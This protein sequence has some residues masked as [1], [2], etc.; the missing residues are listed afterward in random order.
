MPHRR[1]WNLNGTTEDKFINKFS[2][3]KCVVRVKTLLK[4][5]AVFFMNFGAKKAAKLP[6]LSSWKAT[7]YVGLEEHQK[8]HFEWFNELSHE[9]THI[10]HTNAWSSSQISQT[11]RHN[12]S[13]YSSLLFSILKK[14]K[15]ITTIKNTNAVTKKP[16]T[17]LKLIYLIVFKAATCCPDHTSAH[18]HSVHEVHSGML[19]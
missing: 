15:L 17:S 2:E 18:T 8:Q 1:Q 3:F 10:K 7:A 12:Y 4:S 6:L 9:V 19:F 5:N 11:F 16:W 14:K 13:V